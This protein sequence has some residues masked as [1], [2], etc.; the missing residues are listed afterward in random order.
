[1]QIAD[2][3]RERGPLT[4]AAFMELALYE[5]ELGYYARASRRSGRAGDFFTSVDV[6]PLFGEL[7]EIQLA[8]MGR[9]TAEAAEH[10]EPSELSALSA[11][12][13]V[14]A[15]DLVEAGAGDGRLSSD[16]LRAAKRR[17]PAF[18]ES[19]RLHLVDASAEARRAHLETLADVADRL[20]W[21]GSALP[22]SFEGVLVANELL[23]ALPVHQVVMRA[24]GLR[25][26]YVDFAPRTPVAGTEPPVPEYSA[27]VRC[28]STVPEYG[29]RYR[30]QVPGPGTGD[31]ILR[32]G[33]PSTPELAA[34]LDR[35]GV[36]L[37]PDWRVEINLRAVEWIR[38]AARRLTRG[39]IILI[40]YGHEA[41][42]LYSASHSA[43][44]L[45]TFARHRSQ[46]P[47]SSAETPAWLQQPG[48]QDLTAHVDFTSVRAA[49]EADG[50]TTIG[51]LD[52]TYFLLGLVGALELDDLKA[53]MALKTLIMPGG[54]GST[55]KVLILGKGVGSPALRGCSFRVR[56]T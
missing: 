51:L 12:S 30:G 17:D 28:R 54:L 36:V 45:T 27:G 39:F 53:R 7:L 11:R 14:R 55:H 42:D 35:L 41:R 16:I 26:V 20:V 33:P 52:Q 10:A 5:P 56:A 21:S 31:L 29:A 2:L 34:Y 23:D 15:F 24:N 32:E 43:G 50:L 4:V 44:T 48:D 22:E 46:G 3:I 9:L 8:E 6:G 25:E 38:D 37:E 49:A 1:V 19:L 18:Y 13:A 40:D 47:E